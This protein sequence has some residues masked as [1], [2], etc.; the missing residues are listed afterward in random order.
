MRSAFQPFLGV[1]DHLNVSFEQF[2]VV[3]FVDDA[4]YFGCC[5]ISGLCI[6]RYRALVWFPNPL[7]AGSDFSKSD[8]DPIY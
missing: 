1:V 8:R 6:L 5:F 7:A 3:E 4:E 2:D